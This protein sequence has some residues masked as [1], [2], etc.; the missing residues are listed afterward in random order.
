[1]PDEDDDDGQVPMGSDAGNDI[2]ELLEEQMDVVEGEEAIED[3][4][5]E[6]SADDANEVQ[7]PTKSQR[8]RREDLLI[9]LV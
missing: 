7:P 1:M 5:D 6:P 9:L 2:G 3:D 4:E 8:W